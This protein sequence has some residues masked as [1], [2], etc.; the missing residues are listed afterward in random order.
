MILCIY[1]FYVYILYNV[2]ITK[3]TLHNIINK[4]YKM[5]FIY[6]CIVYNTC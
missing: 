5:F 4:F 1:L 6:E 3:Y 2:I